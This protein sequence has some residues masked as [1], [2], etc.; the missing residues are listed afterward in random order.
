MTFVH[1]SPFRR[2]DRQYSRSVVVPLRKPTADTNVIVQAA[3]LGMRAIFRPDYNM[4][5]A[6]VMLLDLQDASIEQQEL[7]LDEPPADRGG[8]M[9]AMDQINAKYGR[10]TL[11]AA[12]AGT[13]GARRTWV[14][15]QARKTP[16]YTTSWDQLPLVRA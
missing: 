15:K 3:I 6:G 11:S 14:M 9:T 10:G 8:L 13:A 2:Q 1:T 7:G 5:K 12:S 4:A 16:D